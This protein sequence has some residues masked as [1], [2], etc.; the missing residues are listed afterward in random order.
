MKTE[1]IINTNLLSDNDISFFNNDNN[2]YDIEY[3]FVKTNNFAS[4][5]VIIVLI[6][7]AKNIGFNAIY[8][9]IKFGLTKIVIRISKNVE[10][11]LLGN[12]ARSNNTDNISTTSKRFEIAYDDKKV[13]F[14]CNFPL[15]SNQVDKIVDAAIEKLKGI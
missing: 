12:T 6:E 4:S 7:L 5:D 13:S 1:I 10:L 2:I 15:S 9:I 8:D 14:E 3:F 11:G